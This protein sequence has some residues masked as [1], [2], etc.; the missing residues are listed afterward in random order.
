LVARAKEEIE[1]L[2]AQENCI[3]DIPLSFAASL[4]AGDFVVW[5]SDDP[6]KFNVF[7]LGMNNSN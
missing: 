4:Q 3:M 7:D 1:A 5:N 2:L 6:E